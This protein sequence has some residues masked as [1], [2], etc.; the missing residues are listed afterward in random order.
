MRVFLDMDGV[1]VNMLRG[2]LELHDRLDLYATCPQEDRIHDVLGLT[3]A[4]TWGPVS[5]AGED[6]WARL[7]KCEWADALLNW[8]YGLGVRPEVLSTP[9]PTGRIED[10]ATSVAGKLRW[11]RGYFGEGF[12]DRRCHFTCDKTIAANQDSLLIDAMDRVVNAFREAGGNAILVPQP[13]N[14]MRAGVGS[15]MLAI[16][17]QYKEIYGDVRR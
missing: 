13:Y 12:S 3:S 15:E 1:L 9:L 14:S 16:T 4:E 17:A 2:I 7:D 11:L 8:V 5:D 6:F 10:V